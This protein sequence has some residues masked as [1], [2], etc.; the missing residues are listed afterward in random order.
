M[1]ARTADH[2]AR[3]STDESYARV[4]LAAQEDARAII[5]QAK[6]QAESILAGA[7]ESARA[8]PSSSLAA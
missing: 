5:E 1:L 2:E 7:A 3:E 6:R 8:A 4:M